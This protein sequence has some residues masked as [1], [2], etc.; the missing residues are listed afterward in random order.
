MYNLLKFILACL[1]ACIHLTTFAQLTQPEGYF[2]SEAKAVA[3]D[4]GIIVSVKKF[5]P[6]ETDIENAM[7]TS[8]VES[9]GDKHSSY[10]PPKEAKDFDE[11]LR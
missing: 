4:S 3:S 11:V 5:N 6:T 2:T 7:I 8:L 10:F 9:L 1:F